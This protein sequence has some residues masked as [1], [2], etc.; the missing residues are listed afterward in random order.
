MVP[1]REVLADVPLMLGTA[2][3]E[4]CKS[5]MLILDVVRPAALSIHA[6]PVLY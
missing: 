1:A 4:A 6:Y 5:S 2:A 3:P